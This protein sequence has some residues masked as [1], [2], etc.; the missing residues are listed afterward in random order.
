MREVSNNL[1]R[2]VV[3]GPVAR[4]AGAV[5]FAVLLVVFL[6]GLRLLD[7]GRVP[8]A[9]VRAVE[10]VE[11]VAAV[12]PPPPP[13]TVVEP[14]PPPPPA[15]LPRLDVQIE[16]VAPALRATLDPRVDLTM[17]T[18]DFEL[19]AEPAPSP[20]LRPPQARGASGGP[21]A[22]PR[23]P[24]QQVKSTYEAGELDAKPRLLN[25]P[26]VSYPSTLRRRG[27]REGR[28]LLEVAISA[29]GRASVRRVLSSSHPEFT[30]MAR[31][32]ASRAR[33]SVPK[34]DG[35]PVTAIYRW[36]L[37]LRP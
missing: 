23:R 25:R 9:T 11:E 29:G 15:A 18:S 24:S 33:F 13:Q 22:A 32:Y 19:E 27:V 7:A 31:S 14:P 30:K 12:P 6:A 5:G 10:T 2:S 4:L 28:V 3:G 37:I 26:S 34:K 21:P 36:P 35:R 20:Q 8:G 1:A 17:R 16:K